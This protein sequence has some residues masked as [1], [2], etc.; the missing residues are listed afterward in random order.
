MTVRALG[1]RAHA[2]DSERKKAAAKKPKTRAAFPLRQ[3]GDPQQDLYCTRFWA[4]GRLQVLE[5]H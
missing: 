2:A 5:Q 3:A 1:T 4:I